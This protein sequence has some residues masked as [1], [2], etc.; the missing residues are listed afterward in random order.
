MIC[1]SHKEDVDGIASAV[2]IKRLFEPKSIVLVDYA[3]MIKELGSIA[4]TLGKKKIQELFICDLALSKKNEAEFVEI[5][6]KFIS[7]G[8]K[9]TYVDHHDLSEETESK[10]KDMDVQLLHNIEE[11]TSVQI[12]Q[13]FQDQLDD[14]A[15]FH[16]AGA[17]L[18]DYMDSKPIASKLVH[19]FDR[20][21]LMLQAS[22]LQYVISANQHDNEFLV[23]LVKTLAEGK[24]THDVKD[25]FSIARSYAEMVGNAAKEIETSMKKLKNLA[26]ASSTSIL[27]TSMVVNFVLGTSGKPVAV[28]YKPRD[29]MPGSCQISVRG[30][31]DCKLHLG[32]I[33]NGIAT[34]LGGNGGGHEKACGAIIPEKTVSKFL[35]LLNRAVD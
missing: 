11:C 33:V 31:Q 35:R 3:N 25:G 6:S 26:Y 24:Y 15:A 27:S 9:V 20:Q 14:H 28:I 8:I 34:E 29:D 13:Q 16:A 2:L 21:F 18:T 32:K 4:D 12:Y 23:S 5:I 22:A 17:A 30:S 7:D 10:L 19:R 1:V